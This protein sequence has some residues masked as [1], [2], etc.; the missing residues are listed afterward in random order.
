[1]KKQTGLQPRSDII[2]LTH[3]IVLVPPGPHPALL[4]QVSV[5]TLNGLAQCQFAPLHL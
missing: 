2:G 1:M 4:T 3:P 5:S